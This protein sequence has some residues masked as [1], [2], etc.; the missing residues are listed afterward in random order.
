M[1]KICFD[2]LVL[3]AAAPTLEATFNRACQKLV[4][5]QKANS[6]SCVMQT[7]VDIP[8]ERI[9]GLKDTYRSQHEE[10]APIDSGI[11]RYEITVIGLKGSVNGLAMALAGFL[12]PKVELPADR[13][14]L[15]QEAKYE[16]N[17]TYPWAVEVFK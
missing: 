14:A 12:V 3:H 15:I 8:A 5:M 9:A 16:Q 1:S 13:L 2:V 4:Q 10:E 6:A 17:A 7:D 11:Y